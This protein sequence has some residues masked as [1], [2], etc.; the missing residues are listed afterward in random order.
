MVEWIEKGKN[1]N[2][3]QKL[4]RTVP[5]QVSANS[6]DGQPELWKAEA[7]PEKLIMQ[8]MPKQ[9]IG[10]IGGAYLKNSKSVLFHPQQCEALEALTKVMSNGFAGCVHFTNSQ[11]NQACDIKVLIL[12][13][14]AEKNA[15]LGFIP[16]D[17]TAFVD[18]LRRVIQQQKHQHQNAAM[19][20]QGLA[21]GPG[22]AM[23]PG[24]GGPQPSMMNPGGPMLVKPPAPGGGSASGLMQAMAGQNNPPGGPGPSPGLQGPGPVGMGGPGGQLPLPGPGAGP[25]SMMQGPGGPR[26]PGGVLGGP[27]P[28]YNDHLEQAR[29]Q[30]LAK[31]QQLRK[32]LEAAQQQEL[33]YKSQMEISSNVQM[34]QQLHQN[35]E[36]AQ[37][38]E[39]QFKVMEIEH[40]KHMRA[41][42]MQQ[43]PGMQRM[44]RPGIPNNPGLRNL[45]QHQQPQFRQQMMGGPGGQQIQQQFDEGVPSFEFLG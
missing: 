35:L 20:R 6:R 25:G 39:N 44:M 43:R 33:N 13:Y 2:D 27:R 21:G 9:L 14:T 15:Y 1:P 16:N 37:Q 23:G 32:T 8:L 5:C 22:N 10:T 36:Q 12:L 34:Q 19:I 18:R 40:Q 31:I 17:Q 30:N 42:L 11:V 24:P 26:G 38:Q 7:W 45:L 28:P 29:Q 41:Q 4:T 3:P